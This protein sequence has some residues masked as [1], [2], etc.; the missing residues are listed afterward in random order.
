MDAERDPN[1]LLVVLLF[2]LGPRL[3]VEQATRTKESRGFQCARCLTS[4]V[5]FG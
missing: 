4:L 3:S 5:S 1:G 2:F